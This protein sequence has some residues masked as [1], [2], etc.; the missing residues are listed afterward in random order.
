MRRLALLLAF[1]ALAIYLSAFD[2]FFLSLIPWAI[3]AYVG[4][5]AVRWIQRESARI[6]SG[7][8]GEAGGA[9]MRALVGLPGPRL[10]WLLREHR[11]GAGLVIG[12]GLALIVLLPLGWWSASSEALRSTL[13]ALPL[14]SAVA[15]EPAANGNPVV[16]CLLAT[17]LVVLAIWLSTRWRM[18]SV[19]A[20]IYGGNTFVQILSVGFIRTV[21][22]FGGVTLV[23]VLGFIASGTDLR[24]E[25]LYTFTGPV[26][27]LIVVACWLAFT[28]VDLRRS[29]E[30]EAQRP[31]PNRL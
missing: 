28:Y 19:R 24:R 22:I 8:E 4:S 1:V 17:L 9:T 13:E 11:R 16:V 26:W 3:V 30:R 31:G 20:Y 15:T 18:H 2:E 14:G 5:G 6:R 7:R 27:P 25:P 10:D 12:T 21:A 23:P 29:Y